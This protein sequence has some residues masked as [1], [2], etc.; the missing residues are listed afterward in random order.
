MAQ[1]MKPGKPG[2]RR[3]LLT[4]ALAAVF[5]LGAGIALSLHRHAPSL[6]D[7]GLPPLP[8]LAGK[9][10]EL[11]KKLT[12][13]QAQVRANHDVPNAIAALGRLYHANG[14]AAEATACWQ[15]LHAS[16]PREGH[17]SYYLSD[18]S[19]TASDTEGL[20]HWLEKTV[21]VAPDYSPAWLQL[22]R[23]GVQ[24]PPV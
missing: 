9:P 18:L 2:T 14:F 19:R 20:Q 15:I 10:A 17:W 6:S 24:A 8:D 16:Q 3:G 12:D 22:R 7:R 21:E 11:R 23:F 1:K 13:L 4:I 5:L